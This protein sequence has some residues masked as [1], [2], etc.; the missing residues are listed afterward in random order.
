M[1]PSSA[2]PADRPIRIANASGFFGDRISAA[3]E[4][5]EG[6]PIDVLTGDWLAELTMLILARQRMKHGPGSGYARTFLTQM[7]QV[8]GTCLDRGI[9]VV[10]NAGGL[11]PAGCAQAL[12][13]K[14]GELGLKP[15]IAV[16]EGD[17]LMGNLDDLKAAGEEFR[18]V[19]TKETLD[20]AGAHLITANAYLGGEGITRALAAGAD[21]VITGRVTD[22]ALTVGPAA[23]WHGWEY[24]GDD[25]AQ[26]DALAGAIVAGHAIECGA[27]VTG[28]NY[29]FF[30]HVPGL[31]HPGFPIAEV[32]ADGSS[33]ITKH[34]GTGGLV[35]V[36]TVT[37]Q[38][39]Y[40]IGSPAYANPDA[41]AMFDSIHLQQIGPDRV[42][43]SGV[44]G[45]PA[46][47][48]LKVAGTYLGGF[49]NTM[50]IV[51]TGL[52]AR[53][54]ADLV[55]RTVCNVDLDQVATLSPRDLAQAS[56][57]DVA[58]LLVDWQ[59]TGVE[60][61]META[62]AQSHLRMTVRDL[63][64]KKVGKTFTAP[65]V[66]AALST[67]PGMFPTA[68]P[69][70]ATPYGIYWPTTVSRDHVDTRVTMDG[71]VIA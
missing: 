15:R 21:V 37:A 9:R 68:P 66:E 8:L 7:E 49:R 44:V 24:S 13:E 33:V 65:I 5:V 53:A 38:L 55:L 32:A 30:T 36:G 16:V 2:G 40:E 69:A 6:G 10:S 47:E 25:Q 18:N 48:T 42:S 11:D 45:A 61:P 52:D 4:M 60:D 14:A 17:D 20:S 1:T 56:S 39:L 43:I 70:E 54:K 41:T 34:D 29:S 62:S 27:Q 28:G 22:A 63:D 58:E 3:R 51:V 23:W 19:D 57:F 46:P 67:Y 64:P 12:A 71:E 59:E 50:S 35:S 26:L 31:E